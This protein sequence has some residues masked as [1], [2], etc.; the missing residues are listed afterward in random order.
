MVEIHDASPIADGPYALFGFVGI[1]ANA[2][3]GHQHELLE[4]A[5]QQFI[6]LFGN[7]AASPI[8]IILQDWAFE[9][10]TATPLDHVGPNHHPNYGLPSSLKTI[11]DG[12]L[13]LGSTEIAPQFGGYIEGALEAADIVF[14]KVLYA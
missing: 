2:R 10:E 5:Q 7:E 11:W 3:K 8:E 9:S 12:Q 13:I 4:A 6:R 1:P 14:G